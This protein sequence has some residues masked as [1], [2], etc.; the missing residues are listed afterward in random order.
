M[1]KRDL[2]VLVADKNVKSAL[3]ALL[4]RRQSLGI[5]QITCDIF[6]HP[7]NDPACALRG[8]EFLADYSTQYRYALLLFDHEGSGQEHL[9]P[10]QLQINLNSRFSSAGWNDRGKAIVLLPELEA[11]VWSDSPHVE[12]V[13]GWRGRQTPLRNWLTERG[14]LLEGEIKPSRPKESFQAALREAQTP[15]SSSLYQQLAERVSFNRCRDA[16]F[17]ELKNTLAQWFS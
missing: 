6:V 3:E 5:R 14:W 15:R 8:V 2:V 9:S 12:D 10:Q 7:Q 13:I 11:W 1:N 16:V 4:A 17:L